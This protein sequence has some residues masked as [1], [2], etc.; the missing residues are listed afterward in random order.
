MIKVE[1]LCLHDYTKSVGINSTN[2]YYSYM[3]GNF[4]VGIEKYLEDNKSYGVKTAI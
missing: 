2:G 1:L 3:S 4:L